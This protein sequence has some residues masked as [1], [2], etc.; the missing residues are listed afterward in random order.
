MTAHNIDLNNP[1]SWPP[2]LTVP[3]VAKIL[4]I[5]HTRAYQ[6]AKDHTLPSIKL[7]KNVRIPRGRFME[8]LD[9]QVTGG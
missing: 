7:G 8:W 6:L 4:K 5:S 3:Q 2:I 9:K 1:E